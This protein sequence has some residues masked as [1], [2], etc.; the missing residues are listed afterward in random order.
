[1]AII[2]FDIETFNSVPEG[3]QDIKSFSPHG[4]AVA[5]C[6]VDKGDGSL[7][8]VL[9]W[10]G[11]G[12]AYTD[13]NHVPEDGIACPTAVVENFLNYL[14]GNLS[15]GSRV[16]SWAGASFDCWVLAEQAGAL[17]RHIALQHIDMLAHLFCVKGFP[18]GV[19]AAAPVSVSPVKPI[20]WAR[21]PRRFG[22]TRE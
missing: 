16:V 13:Q 6:A 22:V 5:A 21:W 18:L 19:D 8:S 10:T 11:A 14:F 2:A 1:M 9:Y 7:P 15:A 20:T 4:T 17:A 3:V 12:N